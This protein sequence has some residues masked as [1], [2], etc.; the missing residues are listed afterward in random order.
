[1]S[2]IRSVLSRAAIHQIDNLIPES[3]DDILAIIENE[4][5]YAERKTD[6]ALRVNPP[7]LLI[8]DKE[9]RDLL[10]KLLNQYEAQELVEE[11]DLDS[12]EN[13][14]SVLLKSR[15]YRGSERERKLF[16]FFGVSLPT[17]EDA[18]EAPPGIISIV[19]EYGLF[20]Y[21]SDVAN[22]VLSYLES[23]DNRA[24]LHMPTGS[25]K[26]R[27]TMSLVSNIIKTSDPGLVLW[28]AEGNELLDQAAKEFQD[29]WIYLGDREIQVS[30][31]YGNYDWQELDEGFI[32]AGLQKLWNKEKKSA[33]FLANLS[34]KVSLVVFDEAHRSAAD[35]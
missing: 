9:S 34:S 28:L 17:E 20:E 23:K 26:T 14:Y 33:A 21:Q 30:R 8:R 12:E 29:A 25:G 3:V 16:D 22:R 24:F 10:F 32:V 11:L 4:S 7:E 18:R 31:F 2:K 35:T 1:M 19:P 15:Y 5:I 6:I 13:P 27:I